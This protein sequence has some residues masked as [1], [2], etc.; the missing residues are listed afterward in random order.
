MGVIRSIMR[1]GTAGR[2]VSIVGVF[3]LMAFYAQFTLAAPAGALSFSG[4]FSPTI[5]SGGADLNGDGAADVIDD[6]TA[7][8]GN[9]DIINGGLDCD[10]WVGDNEQ[11]LACH[12]K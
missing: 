12:R 9:T 3:A 8:Y 5:F 10:A 7:F 1:P 4:G 6:S 2:R 11:G